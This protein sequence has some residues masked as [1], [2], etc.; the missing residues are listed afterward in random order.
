[1]A[2]SE[3]I[4]MKSFYNSRAEFHENPR[5]GLVAVTTSRT[6]LCYCPHKAFFHYCYETPKNSVRTEQSSTY[7]L[8]YMNQMV[9]AIKGSDPCLF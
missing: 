4:F 2:L 9:K 1:M 5:D 7:S 6:D 3:P 8:H